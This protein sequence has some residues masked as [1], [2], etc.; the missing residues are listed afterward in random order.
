MKCRPVSTVSVID[1]LL[2]Q[3]KREDGELRT[4]QRAEFAMNTVVFFSFD[5][6]GIMIPLGIHLTGGLEHVLRA[7]VNAQFTALAAVWY[8]VNLSV[9]GFDVIDVER[10]PIEYSHRMVLSIIYPLELQVHY[11]GD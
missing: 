1:H 7:E 5:D 9:W 11:T 10:F 2:R 4:D 8:E 3:L 6:R